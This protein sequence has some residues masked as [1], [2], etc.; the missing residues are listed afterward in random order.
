ME[1]YTHGL[2]H[3]VFSVSIEHSGLIH[4][5]AHSSTSFFSTANNIPFCGHTAL[6]TP[7]Y[8]SMNTWVVSA[9][10][11]CEHAAVYICVRAD[12][13]FRVNK[14]LD[15]NQMNNLQYCC[16]ALC[17]FLSYIWIFSEHSMEFYMDCLDYCWDLRNSYM[18]K[19]KKSRGAD[20]YFLGTSPLLSPGFC[21]KMCLSGERIL[22][23]GAKTKCVV[24]S[25]EGYCAWF[26]P[27]WVPFSPLV[28]KLLLRNKNGHHGKASQ[29]GCLKWKEKVILFCQKTSLILLIMKTAFF[30]EIRWWLLSII[31]MT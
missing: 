14:S 11:C 15:Q 30:N 23:G 27:G 31:W 17:F 13:D 10:G 6:C 9:F 19:K 5:V 1:L 4:G 18:F 29:H 26:D 28:L 2:L 25:T 12:I 22:E 16:P 20:Y 3:V 8:Q 7:T 24:K 21:H